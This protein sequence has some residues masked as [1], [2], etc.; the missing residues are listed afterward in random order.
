MGSGHPFLNG[1]FCV[2]S[3]DVIDDPNYCCHKQENHYV[4][5]PYKIII[6]LISLHDQLELTPF[7]MVGSLVDSLCINQRTYLKI[8]S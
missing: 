4:D 7:Y 2:V 3:E 8:H 1:I 5:R 6:H